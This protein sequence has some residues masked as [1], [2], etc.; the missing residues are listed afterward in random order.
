MHRARCAE[1]TVGV[2]SRSG[3]GDYKVADPRALVDD[4]VHPGP[5][6]RD[7]GR[8]LFVVGEQLPHSRHAA[9]SLFLHGASE[10]DVSLGFD[11][12]GVECPD[13]RQV[14]SQSPGVITDARRI[15]AAI[16]FHRGDIRAESKHCIQVSFQQYSGPLAFSWPFA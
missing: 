8:D 16:L 14:R 2:P 6:D 5:I 13:H 11:T 3:I 9:Q 15:Y 10:N 7:C 4:G 12:G 1:C